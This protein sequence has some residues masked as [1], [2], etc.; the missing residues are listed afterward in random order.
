M[1]RELA[2]IRGNVKGGRTKSKARMADAEA[3]FKEHNEQA[4]AERLQGVRC[5]PS[6]PA[7]VGGISVMHMWCVRACSYGFLQPITVAARVLLLYR[8]ALVSETRFL[9]SS[10]SQSRIQGE[11]SCLRFVRSHSNKTNA[12]HASSSD[13]GIA[14]VACFGYFDFV[15]TV[16]VLCFASVVKYFAAEPVVDCFAGH[17]AWHYRFQWVWEKYIAAADYRRRRV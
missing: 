14:V 8:K 1:E 13:D 10:M 15:I 4:A 3:M 6:V 16:C 2:W 5:A 17:A 11:G 12:R 9:N 7:V